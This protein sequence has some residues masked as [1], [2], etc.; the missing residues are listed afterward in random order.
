MTDNERRIIGRL[1][2][3]LQEHDNSPVTKTYAYATGVLRARIRLLI[4]SIG[5]DTLQ[6]EDANP[7][8]TA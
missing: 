7:S 3:M 2:A 6:Y 4:A 1:E 5:A 8:P